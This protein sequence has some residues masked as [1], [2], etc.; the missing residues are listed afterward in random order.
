MV[1]RVIKRD[2]RNELILKNKKKISIGC[3]NLFKCVIFA[4]C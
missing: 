2:N 3:F 4:H 1:Y